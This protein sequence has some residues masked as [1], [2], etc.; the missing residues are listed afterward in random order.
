MTFCP[1]PRSSVRSSRL[2]IRKCRVASVVPRCE[3]E[4]LLIHPGGFVVFSVSAGCC[5]IRAGL[6]YVASRG[7]SG[8]PVRF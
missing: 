1:P 2:Q 4:G 8:S 5:V 6:R 3:R 7:G